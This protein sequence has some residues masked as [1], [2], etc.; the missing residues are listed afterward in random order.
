MEATQLEVYYIVGVRG[1]LTIATAAEY[2]LGAI[3]FH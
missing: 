2:L 1:A 3:S